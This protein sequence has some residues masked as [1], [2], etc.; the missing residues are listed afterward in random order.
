MEED[1]FDEFLVST[2]HEEPESW[3]KDYNKKKCPD[4]SSLHSTDAK[5]CSVCGW[6]PVFV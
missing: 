6:S 2:G 5:E 4:C 1:V 3:E